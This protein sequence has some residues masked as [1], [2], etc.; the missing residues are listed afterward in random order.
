MVFS[1]EYTECKVEVEGVRLKQVRETVC[2]GLRLG[3][4]G[5]MESELGAD[6]W[7]SSY[8]SRGTERGVK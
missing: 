8:R 5:G 4:N 2:L 3:D 7:H 6:D 1:K